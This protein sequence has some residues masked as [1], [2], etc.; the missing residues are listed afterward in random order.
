MLPRLVLDAR[1]IAYNYELRWHADAPKTRLTLCG[2]ELVKSLYNFCTDVPEYLI[3][4]IAYSFSGLV[5]L[6]QCQPVAYSVHP[7]VPC[8]R[9][10]DSLALGFVRLDPTTFVNYNTTSFHIVYRPTRDEPRPPKPLP[11]TTA[12]KARRSISASVAVGTIPY[13]PIFASHK[14]VIG[15]KG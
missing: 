3:I 7:P 14:N 15:T 12:S 2:E 13:L 8:H 6:Y 11:A 1:I 4:F 5:V 10:H 9:S